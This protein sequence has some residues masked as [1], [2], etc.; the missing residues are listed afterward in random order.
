MSFKMILVSLMGVVAFIVAVVFILT[1]G[2]KP[3]PATT[4]YSVQEN[5]RPRAEV[6]QDFFDL[7][8]MKVSAVGQKDFEIKNTGTQQLQILNINSSCNCT[9]GQVIYQGKISKEFGMHAQSGFVTEIAPGDTATVRVTYRPVIMPVYGPVEREVYLTTND[10]DNGKLIFRV[11][12][13]VK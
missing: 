9:F 11:K 10:P 3:P 1:P 8:E 2:Q 6:G 7:G 12:A 5:A 13:I 4:S